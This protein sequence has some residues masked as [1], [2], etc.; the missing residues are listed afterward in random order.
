[1]GSVSQVPST[2]VVHES[3]DHSGSYL[4]Q[5]ALHDMWRLDHQQRGLFTV[6]ELG[7]A[8]NLPFMPHYFDKTKPWEDPTVLGLQQILLMRELGVLKDESLVIHF[9]HPAFRGRFHSFNA[10]GLSV[11]QLY[12]TFPNLETESSGHS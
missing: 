2:S 6:V 8:Y 4:C 5:E 3:Q 7:Y 11:C 12:A 1:M 10:A 9:Y